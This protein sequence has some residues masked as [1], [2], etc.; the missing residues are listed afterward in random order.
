MYFVKVATAGRRKTRPEK[1]VDDNFVNEIW[2]RFFGRTGLASLFRSPR[3][4]QFEIPAG[5]YIIFKKDLKTAYC[6]NQTGRKFYEHQKYYRTCNCGAANHR[7]YA[8]Y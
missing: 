4:Y 8:K 1:N 6:R 2:V 5:K 7:H 3:F